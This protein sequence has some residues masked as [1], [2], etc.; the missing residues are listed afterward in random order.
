MQPDYQHLKFPYQRPSDFGHKPPLH[1]PVVVVGA[2]PVGLAA[3]IDLAR[4]GI[5]VVVL[6]DLLATGGTLSA[7]ISLLR[8]I[9]ADVVGAAQRGAQ[10]PLI[11]HRPAAKAPEQA[12][13]HLGCGRLGIGQA[14][15]AL[16]LYPV[17]QQPRHPVG[18]DTGLARP[19]IRRQPGRGSGVRRLHLPFACGVAPHPTSSGLGLSVMSHS[20]NRAR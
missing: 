17:Q 9:G 1:V 12:V 8:S 18:Q 7:A 14:Q 20:P 11:Q 3:A 16:R 15:N 19:G 5:R 4:R 10:A 13:L 2:G 6:D